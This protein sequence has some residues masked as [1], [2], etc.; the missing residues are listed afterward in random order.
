MKGKEPLRVT[1]VQLLALMG[2]TFHDKGETHD[3]QGRLKFYL[4]F[5][6]Y[7]PP[8]RQRDGELMTSQDFDE[9]VHDAMRT[10]LFQG[11]AEGVTGMVVFECQDMCSSH[12]GE[13]KGLIY[14]PG[15]TFKTLDDIWWYD[16]E[17]GQVSRLDCELASTQKQPVCYYEKD[18]A[19]DPSGRSPTPEATEAAPNS[20]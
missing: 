14:G 9:E 20:S 11:K 5:P 8:R 3:K 17:R 19:D 12:L 18:P 10:I 4:Y 7:Q 16:K 15:C 1:F 13:R 6:D 2:D